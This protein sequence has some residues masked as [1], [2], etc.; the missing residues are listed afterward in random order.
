MNDNVAYFHSFGVEPIPN[1]FR[2]KIITKDIYRIQKYDSIM[3][4]YFCIECVDCMF[5]GENLTRFTS[6]FSPSNFE[7]NDKVI[8]NYFLNQNST[9]MVDKK[10][11]K[12]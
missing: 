8:L 10:K 1:K 11:K 7:N 12:K 6:L 3:C 2:G 4:G 5:K 9:R